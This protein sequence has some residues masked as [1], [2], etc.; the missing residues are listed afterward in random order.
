MAS[1]P[2]FLEAWVNR[3]DHRVFG[4]RLRPLSLWHLLALDAID[5]PFAGFGDGAASTTDF[6]RAVAILATEPPETLEIHPEGIEPGIWLAFCAIPF[7]KKCR[8]ANLQLKAYFS[9][10][11]SSVDVWNFTNGEGGGHRISAPWLLA[12]AVFLMRHTNLSER[13]IW[14]A[15]IGQILNYAAAVEEQVTNNQVISTDEQAAMEEARAQEE[16]EHGRN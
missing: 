3:R 10:F 11:Y 2:R 4:C 15:P 7:T 14:T 13:R 8:R 12:R 9:D 5:S 6:L 16:A 1:D